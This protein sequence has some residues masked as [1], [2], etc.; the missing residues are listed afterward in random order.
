VLLPIVFI[1]LLLLLLLLLS[2][3]LFFLV[4]VALCIQVRVV[5]RGLQRLRL[6]RVHHRS[7]VLLVVW[8]QQFLPVVQVAGI[9][10]GMEL[11]CLLAT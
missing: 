6:I 8:L 4:L 7:I 10:S 1:L 5:V 11:V 9:R 3:L 2:L